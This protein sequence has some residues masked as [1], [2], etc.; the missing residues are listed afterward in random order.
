VYQVGKEIKRIMCVCV[1]KIA[2]DLVTYKLR[3]PSPEFGCCA[4]VKKVFCVCVCVCVYVC[5]CVWLSESSL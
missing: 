1:C 5:V 4:T 2:R 3:L